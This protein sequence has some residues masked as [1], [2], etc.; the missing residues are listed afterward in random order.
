MTF[1][2]DAAVSFVATH[3][4]LLERRRLD[5]FLGNGTPEAVLA[6]L[7]AY[8][9]ADGGYGWALEPD[10]RSSG[11]QPVAA[12]HALEV[13][14]EIRDT[15]TRR[16]V[17]ILDWLAGHTFAD[18]GVPFALPYTD[19]EGS[20]PHWSGADPTRSS[21][22]M[23]S[24]LA[25]QGHRL[26]RYRDD[27]AGHPWLAGATRYCLTTIEELPPQPQAYQLMFGLRLLDAVAEREP[28]ALPLLRRCAALVRLDGPTLVHGG[29]PGEALH[30]L[31]FAPYAGTPL[32]R[33]FPA[34]AVAAG[35]DRLAG[36]QRPD[37]G[38]AVDFPVYS[39]AAALDWRGYATVQSVRVLRGAGL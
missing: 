1:D 16:P 39:P 7:D 38:W 21:L 33:V 11:S 25:A 15:R 37:G 9:N 3:A 36:Q 24:Q 12:M 4:R 31:D 30:L 23:T 27:V 20:A 29:A 26:A 19:S 10:L 28:R 2:P 34:G 8:R 35:L 18:G 32:R 13:L 6:G 14:A 17:E 5:L 22:Q